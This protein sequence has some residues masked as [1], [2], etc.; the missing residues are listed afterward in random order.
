[1]CGAQFINMECVRPLFKHGLIVELQVL[2]AASEVQTA[3]TV[4]SVITHVIAKFVACVT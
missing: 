2:T 3:A 1:M 4:S